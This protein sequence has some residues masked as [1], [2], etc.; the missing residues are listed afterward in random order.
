MSDTDRLKEIRERKAQATA[1]WLTIRKEA[2]TD[3]RFVSGN[4]WDEADTKER[5]GRPTVA[6]E[7]MAQYRN[8]VIN[9][10]MAN[11]RGMKFSPTGNGATD[12]GAEFYQNKARE[13]EYRSHATI[14]YI[15]AASCAIERSYGFVRVATRYASSRSANQE[16]WIEAF[17]DPD[18]VLIDDEAQLPDSSDMQFAFVSSWTEQT[19]HARR[20]K[21]KLK[22]LHEFAARHPAWVSGSKILEA[23]YWAI[24]TRPRKLLLVQ[25][26][27]TPPQPGQ[28]P[29]QPGQPPPQPEQ[30]QIFED[31]LSQLPPG[32]QVVRELRTVDYPKVTQVFTNGLEILGEVTEWPGKYIPIVSC[33]GKVIYVPSGGV[34][35]RQLLSM[36][37]FGRDPWKS[38]CY[39][40]SQQLE[41][42]SQV[43]KANVT[44]VAGQLKNYEKDWEE[45]PFRPKAWLYYNATTMATGETILPPPSRLAYLQ[46][47]NLSAL[48]VVKEGN[49]R[50]IQ[51][52]MGSNF[53]PTQA[54][55]RNEKSGKALD[56]M[57]QSAA[58]GTYHFVYA[59]EG[60]IRQV[61]VIFEDLCDK[62]HDYR[63]DVG[64]ILADG[65]AEQVAINDPSNPES[66]STKGDYLCTVSSGPSSDSERDA[67]DDFTQTLVGNIA[68]IAQIAGPKQALAVFAH[69]IRMRPELGAMGAQL[70]DLI[71]P[72]Q[73]GEDGK[74][75][76][77]V[78]QQMHAQLQ[79]MG[80]KLQQAEQAIHTKVAEKQV[81]TQSHEKIAELEIASKERIAAA[82]LEER[83]KDREAKLAVAEET[84]KTERMALF[85]E[86]RDRLGITV[87]S[88]QQRLHDKVE[89]AHDRVHE[90]NT[91]L[92]DHA[93]AQAQAAQGHD[94]ALEAGQADA[95]IASAAA[96]QGQA[97]ALESGQQAADL[98]PVP[99]PEA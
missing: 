81:E 64:V 93:T 96:D 51:S 41:I 80:Q 99:E 37:R 86:E 42:I 61:G 58:Q 84:A 19:E 91:A 12:A 32:C 4:P 74:P 30:R 83:A 3:M 45:A 11:P 25:L 2:E 23:E 39:A 97:H 69:S 94:Q 63:G 70:A 98:A 18:L 95:A 46:G 72:P 8:Q 82:E 89:R 90:L 92:V 10:L 57:E 17:P 27:P 5:E 44:A 29:P 62:I 66:I 9:G 85:L 22:H 13:T 52:A 87:E 55:R 50:A 6:P 15:T 14:A 56:K 75:I 49:R 16:I 1:G 33:F 77:P 35:K 24:T 47:E 76:P 53:L 60:M 67:A 34:T 73:P 38:Y 71:D 20:N 40:C 65:K 68:T 28:R 78:V 54:Q 79:E 36:T 7:E 26:P 59:Y 21:L 43:P 88:A 31:E 48:E